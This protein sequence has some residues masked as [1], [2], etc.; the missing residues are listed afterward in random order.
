MSGCSGDTFVQT[1]ELGIVRINT[2]VGRRLRFWD[3]HEW[4]EGV[5]CRHGKQ[6][7]YNVEFIGAQVFECSPNFPFCVEYANHHLHHVECRDLRCDGNSS[8][9]NHHVLVS[10][11]YSDS[12]HVYSSKEYRSKFLVKR[13]TANNHFIDDL[14]CSSFNKGVVLGR[15]ASNGHYSKRGYASTVRLIVAE[16]EYSIRDQLYD[17][18]KGWNPALHPIQPRGKSR[19]ELT[20][21]ELYS[22]ALRNELLALDLRN[23]IADDFFMDTALLRGLLRGWFDGDGTIGQH[24]IS[25]T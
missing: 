17:Y 11:E 4:T 1:E 18:A 12:T 25:L 16:H 5:V 20:Y 23:H 22:T 13:R 10:P 19:Q 8:T 24:N 15:L 14:Q 7:V 9:H 2:I 3:G 6:P 21:I